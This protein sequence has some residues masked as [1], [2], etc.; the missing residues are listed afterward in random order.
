M[1]GGRSSGIS[2]SGR[3]QARRSSD[4]DRMRRRGNSPSR[5]R[6]SPTNSRQRRTRTGRRRRGRKTLPIAFAVFDVGIEARGFVAVI[7]ERLR[8]RDVRHVFSGNRR[9][10]GCI[11]RRWR[12]IG[13]RI[14]I[15][16]RLRIDDHRAVVVAAAIMMV[17]PAMRP[18]I[19][20]PT[21]VRPNIV[22]AAM[23]TPIGRRRICQNSRCAR[24]E[25]DEGQNNAHDFVFREG[26]PRRQP[27]YP[28]AA[29]LTAATSAKRGRFAQS[30]KLTP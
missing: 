24:R 13:I 22:R 8:R 2:T 7:P 29:E 25:Q 3:S 17:V 14:R 5:H 16:T 23:I 9:L 10:A 12:P 21:I 19:V 4:G 1:A 28:L 26:P 27:G 18:A 30:P 11:R 6:N 20:R 15:G